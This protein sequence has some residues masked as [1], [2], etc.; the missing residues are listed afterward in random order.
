MSGKSEYILS[1][2]DAMEILGKS[3]FAVNL[4][5][6][7]GYFKAVKIQG[8]WRIDIYSLYEFKTKLEKIN[9]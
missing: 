9:S 6:K 3:N 1:I 2:K 4:W 5:R 8:M 7:N